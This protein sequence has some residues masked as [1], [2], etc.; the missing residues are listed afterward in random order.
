MENILLLF[1]IEVIV[2]VTHMCYFLPSRFI[3]TSMT[4]MALLSLALL[5][6]PTVAF[7]PN[8]FEVSH[9]SITETAL[10]QKV[11]EACQA[12]AQKDGHEFVPTVGLM[13][14]PCQTASHYMKHTHLHIFCEHKHINHK[15]HKTE[16]DECSLY[17]MPYFFLQE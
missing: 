1:S 14:K 10:L 2:L 7:F 12:V 9:A 13:V 8:G 15:K 11:T 4:R 5:V 3:M 17:L 6:G 16:L